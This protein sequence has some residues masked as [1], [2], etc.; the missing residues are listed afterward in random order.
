M[1]RSS[2]ASSGV[3]D[4]GKVFMLLGDKGDGKA[5]RGPG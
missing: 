5:A 1:R 2:L 3:A 4:I